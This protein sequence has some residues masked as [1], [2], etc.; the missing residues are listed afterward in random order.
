MVRFTPRVWQSLLVHGHHVS[1]TQTG[2]KLAAFTTVGMTNV[3]SYLVVGLVVYAYFAR[4]VGL[5]VVDGV[6]RRQFAWVLLGLFALEGVT[7]MVP[8]IYTDIDEY[9]WECNATQSIHVVR[10]LFNT[11]TLFLPKPRLIRT[12]KQK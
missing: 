1:V 7:G 5:N 11:L 8:A 3:I 12:K 6:V 4:R 2:C 10:K 9:F